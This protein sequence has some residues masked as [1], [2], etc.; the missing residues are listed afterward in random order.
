MYADC[1]HDVVAGVMNGIN[2]TIFA[3]GQTGAGKTYTMSGEAQYRLRG[4][5]PRALSQ[6]FK[7]VCERDDSTT[8]IRYN[9]DVVANE[10][11]MMVMLPILKDILPGDIQ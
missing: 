1:A 10:M 3:Y 7:T 2:G 11:V 5:I 9:H 6:I 4:I 8:I